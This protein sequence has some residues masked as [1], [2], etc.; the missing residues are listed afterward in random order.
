M[1]SPPISAPELAELEQSINQ[2]T[3]AYERIHATDLLLGQYVYTFPTRARRLLDDQDRLLIANPDADYRLS[4]YLHLGSLESQEYHFPAA[5]RALE[6]AVRIVEERGD[7]NEKLEVYLDYIGALVN[8][9]EM[10]LASEYFDRCERL[11]ENYPNPRMQARANCRHG[12]LYLHFYS[13]PKATVKFLEANR[14]LSEGEFPLTLKDHYFYSLVH[15]GLGTVWNQSGRNERAA[16]AFRLAIERCEEKGLVGRLPWHQLNLG[17]EL[18]ATE[19]YREAVTYFQAVIDSRANGS[20]TALAGAYANIGICFYNL[21]EDYATVNRLF[22]H[23]EELYRSFEQ[24]D[25]TQLANIDFVRATILFQYARYPETIRQ[26]N[27]TLAT[28]DVDQGAPNPPLLELVADTYAML[29]ECHARIEDYRSAY[30]H[31]RS[32]DYYLDQ[33]QQMAD[34]NRQQQFQAQFEAERREKET[35]RLRLKASQLQLRALRAQMN[36]HFMYNALNSIQSFISTNDSATASRYLAK[37]AA[38]MRQSLEY[39][40]REFISL[41][42]ETTFLRDYL[43][44]NKHLRFEGNL[45]YRIVVDEELEEDIIGIPSMILQPYVENAIEHGLRG[46]PQGHIDVIFSPGGE[47]AILATVTDDGIGR[48]RVARM[49]AQDP[50][51]PYHQSRGTDITRSRL[52]LLSQDAEDKVEIVDLFGEEGQARGTRVIVTIPTTDILPARRGR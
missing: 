48:E 9:E 32:Y 19:Q 8:A 44:I 4:Y 3:P 16:V 14:L 21:G 42:E 34:I 13:Y 36:P 23:A 2:D 20:Q 17:K 40:N 15:S 12:F 6:Q 27:Q 49:Q 22:D 10:E 28:A 41:E 1:L 24:P 11:L 43:E 25:R 30:Q 18:I 50:L 37:F 7:L 31:Q 29:A 46:R 35:E 52:E 51:R 38:L 26:L 39:T 47:N 45:T 5:R 33:Y